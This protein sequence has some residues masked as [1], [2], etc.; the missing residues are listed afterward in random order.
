MGFEECRPQDLHQSTKTSWGQFCAFLIA[1]AAAYS[2]LAME[3]N[4]IDTE[5]CR[6][7]NIALGSS[8]VELVEARDE[9][10]SVH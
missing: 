6:K 10:N 7:I 1:A 5:R 4:T 3:G 9:G 2:I 8:K